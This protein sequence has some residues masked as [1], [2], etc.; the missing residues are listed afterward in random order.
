MASSSKLVKT[1]GSKEFVDFP[2]LYLQKIPAKVDTGADSSTIW[3]SRIKKTTD[4]QLAF[5]LF[6]RV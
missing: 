5:V 1:V 2:E 6:G 3:T 4:D